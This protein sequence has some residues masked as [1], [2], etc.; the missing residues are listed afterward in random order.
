MSSL[1]KTLPSGTEYIIL[2]FGIY[3][4]EE[5]NDNIDPRLIA[6]GTLVDSSG[7]PVDSQTAPKL[8][9]GAVPIFYA[10]NFKLLLGGNSEGMVII[11]VDTISVDFDIIEGY[12]YSGDFYED[13]EHERKIDEP[14][15]YKIYKDITNNENKYYYYH[16]I[17]ELSYNKRSVELKKRYAEISN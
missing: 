14:D 5:D 10:N 11:P 3:A 13:S 2:G 1:R 17:Y 12:Y 9:A 16:E 6:W 8:V 7:D 15:R 4:K